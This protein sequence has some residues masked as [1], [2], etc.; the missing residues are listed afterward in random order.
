MADIVARIAARYA[1]GEIN[2]HEVYKAVCALHLAL[3]TLI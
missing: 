1:A 2:A 3:N